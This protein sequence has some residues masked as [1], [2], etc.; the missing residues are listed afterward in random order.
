MNGDIMLE[1][2]QLSNLIK[3]NMMSVNVDCDITG[4]QGRIICYIAHDN[5]GKDVFQ[6]NIEKYFCI[7]RST[8]TG[9]LKLMEKRGLLTK[10]PVS[11]DKRLKKLVLTKEAEKIRCDIDQKRENLEKC[12][13]EGIT[14]EE[15]DVF[16][17][18]TAK[19]KENLLNNE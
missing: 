7:R 11:H 14:Q 17:K 1:I 8:A 18:V 9:I 2:R 16:F 15:L 10:E 13:R 5:A 6:H 3:R 12:I 4:M 19:I